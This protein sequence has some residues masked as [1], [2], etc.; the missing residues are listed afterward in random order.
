VG[1]QRHTPNISAVRARTPPSPAVPFACVRA[2]SALAVLT[3]ASLLAAGGGGCVA[4]GP[5]PRRAPRALPPQPAGL[6]VDR[7]VFSVEQPP[8]DTDRDGYFDSYRVRAY[9]FDHDYMAAI[10]A[11]GEFTFRLTDTRGKE[12]A[13]WTLA[14]A[15]GEIL[16]GPLDP[17]PG[18]RFRLNMREV[19]S[20]HV[21]A[22]EALLACG[23]TTADGRTIEALG[24]VT[25]LVGTTR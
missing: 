13:H 18:R 22:T 6:K 15:Q 2:R 19:G 24:Q 4:D 20:D 14:P 3:V 25:V 21:E 1:N 5:Q 10:E 23:F 11:P 9:L 12:L 7:V 17:G 8:D 16:D